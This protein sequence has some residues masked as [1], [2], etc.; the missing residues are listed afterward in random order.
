MHFSPNF[1]KIKEYYE[2]KKKS[3]QYEKFTLSSPIT[4]TQNEHKLSIGTLLQFFSDSNSV[5]F[6]E[7]KKLIYHRPDKK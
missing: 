3:P 1:F 7:K 4:S 2:T 6:I 5:E